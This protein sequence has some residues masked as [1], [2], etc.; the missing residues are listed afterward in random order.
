[1]NDDWYEKEL[2]HFAAQDGDL[3]KVR[4]LV[5]KG[6]DVSAFDDDLSLTPL[7]YAAKNEH[8]DVMKYLLSVGADVNARDEGRIAETPLGEV[9]ATCSYEV[10]ELLVRAGA[11]PSIKGW[12]QLTALDHARDRKNAE[13]RRVYELFLQTAGEGYH[14]EA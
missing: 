7:H 10:A 13:G 12:M 2:L 14:H 9:A 4:D 1:M 11:N 8:I 5:E 6:Y 3:S